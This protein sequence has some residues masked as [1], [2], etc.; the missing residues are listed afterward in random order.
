MS[1]QIIRSQSASTAQA[2]G[3]VVVTVMLFA[4][5][6]QERNAER[7]SFL[8]RVERIMVSSDL[9]L[10]RALHTIGENDQWYRSAQDQ[11]L[12]SLIEVIRRDHPY[13][14]AVLRHND[15]I[16]QLALTDPRRLECGTHAPLYPAAGKTTLWINSVARMSPRAA[17]L[18]APIESQLD[19][20][21]RGMSHP[22]ITPITMNEPGPGRHLLALVSP[23]R[24]GTEKVY[25]GLTSAIVDPIALVTELG[26]HSDRLRNPVAT[27]VPHP[28]SI[29]H[30]ET[31]AIPPIWC[32]LSCSTYSALR[33]AS[34]GGANW[35]IKISE[36]APALLVRY[37]GSMTVA[38]LG[39]ILST[40]WFLHVRRAQLASWQVCDMVEQRE[41]E[42]VAL[43]DI[44]IE[45]IERRKRVMDELTR[46]Q[47]QLRQLSDHHA[48]I[49][50][51]ERK[52]IAREIH[53][54]L[55]QTMMVLRIDLSL[56]AKLE[57]NPATQMRIQHALAQIDQ[58]VT[59]MRLIINELRP[60]VLDLGLDAAIEWE[61]NK[62]ARR[63]G[64]ECTL[65]LD[66]ADAELPDE[67]TTA[68]YR[69]AQES[70]TNI[71]RHS[72]A[73][74]TAIRLWIEKDWLFM[75]ISDN[76][77][78][79]KEGAPSNVESF[80]LIGMAERIFGLGGA[81]HTE[82]A[83]GQGTTLLFAAPLAKGGSHEQNT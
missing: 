41:R 45:D 27:F 17:A 13:I 63:S 80:G 62:F 11:D 78:G 9:Q 7:D 21:A 52:R 71:M 15:Q 39:L 69:I 12:C 72:Q 22:G 44:L 24:E 38:L 64:I 68:F 57:V 14:I 82:S 48:R 8:N 26:E 25:R 4:T 66:I 55:G 49:K 30:A 83:P 74:T 77:I 73:T 31:A 32:L 46:S 5:F 29:N 53:D 40:L 36:T 70:L 18:N 16:P 23:R 60:A 33:H 56:I 76:G 2:A 75:K 67:L 37:R 81:F 42:M 6:F 3:I 34:W 54:D 65:D 61:S 10:Q 43:N 1:K 79:M 58:T 20:A 51:E 35:T 19:I 59:A 50:E 47:A 28:A